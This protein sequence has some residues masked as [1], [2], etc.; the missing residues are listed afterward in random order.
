MAKGLQRNSERTPEHT[1]RIR[2]ESRL[3]EGIRSSDR[4]HFDAAWGELY[5]RYADRVAVGISGRVP[6]RAVAED[7]VQQ[8][9]AK[10][11]ER[12]ES[13]EPDASFY[14]WVY[15]IAVNLTIDLYRKTKRSRTG[16]LDDQIR[17]TTADRG[18]GVDRMLEQ[19][20]TNARVQ[21]AIAQLTP[22]QAEAIRLRELD[23]MPYKEIAERL[24]VPEGTIM[25]R[26]FYGRKR[27]VQLLQSERPG[28]KKLEKNTAAVSTA[29]TTD[30]EAIEELRKLI[31]SELTQA[32]Q[33]SETDGGRMQRARRDL[34]EISQ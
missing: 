14:T 26:V 27:L 6:D 29:S 24:G 32:G 16:S 23:H 1:Q 17:D 10:A 4:A 11:A 34:D 12:I 8:A 30:S 9:F 5:K 21:E 2:E 3:I 7:I 13:F 28:L 33:G 15:K 22:D 25:A 20:V 19:R 18:P 31:E